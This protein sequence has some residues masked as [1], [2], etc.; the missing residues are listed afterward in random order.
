[1]ISVCQALLIPTHLILITI[2]KISRL[3]IAQIK[4]LRKEDTFLVYLF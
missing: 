4:Q 1:M 3:P 2:C